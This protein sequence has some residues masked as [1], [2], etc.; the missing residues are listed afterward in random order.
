MAPA[1]SLPTSNYLH[2][3]MGEDYSANS[4]SSLTNELGEVPRG[5]LAM[6]FPPSLKLLP[7]DREDDQIGR[8]ALRGQLH[9]W[10]QVPAT[11]DGRGNDWPGRQDHEKWSRTVP[12]GWVVMVDDDD[13]DDD[14]GDGGGGMES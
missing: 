3:T 13:D 9:V 14:D 11:M 10:V 12:S 2:I 8:S 4:Q 1:F 6:P 7:W 5:I